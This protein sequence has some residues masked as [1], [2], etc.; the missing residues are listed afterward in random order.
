ML[1]KGE[2][3]LTTG[4][5]YSL[6]GTV[7]RSIHPEDPEFLTME[8]STFFDILVKNWRSCGI[9][10]VQLDTPSKVITFQECAKILRQMQGHEYINGTDYKVYE[11]LAYETQWIYPRKNLMPFR[12]STLKA[13]PSGL[14][15]PFSETL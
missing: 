7:Q 2:R 6:T 12:D 15:Q 4:L 11:S 3:V 9:F 1:R 5:G 8:F 10:L 13:E 14:N